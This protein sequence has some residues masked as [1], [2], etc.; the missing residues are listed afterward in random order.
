[1]KYSNTDTIS[2]LKEQISGMES[3]LKVAKLFLALFGGKEKLKEMNENITQLKAQLLEF[4]TIPDKFNSLFSKY[5]WIAYETINFEFMKKQIQLEESGKHEEAMNGFFEYYSNETISFLL[6]R[7]YG[8]DEARIRI[9]FIQNAFIDYKAEKYYAMIPVVIMMIDGIVNDIIGKGFHT[10]IES[11]DVWDSITSIDNGIN[12]IQSVFRKG[13]YKTRIEPINEPYRNGILHGI[14]LGYAN[15]TVAVKTWNYLFVVVD[16]AKAKKSEDAR[17]AKF[18]KDNEPVKL[19]TVLEKIQKTDVVKKE[20]EKW[21]KTEYSIEYINNLNI[22]PDEAQPDTAEYI[23][24]QYFKNIKLKNYKELSVLFWDNYFYSTMSR[25]QQIKNDYKD[26]S[27]NDF[28]IIEIIDEAPVI[29][30]ILI[31]TDDKKL[32][33]RLI[34]QS[35]NEDIALPVLENGNWRIVGVREV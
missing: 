4:E 35:K 33:M 31:K 9:D 24:I 3:L 1:M 30:E 29:K 23:C 17:R 28:V 6:N 20:V 13:R 2:K 26:I 19:K 15:K 11:F 27:Y 14:D 16:W 21:T 10:E 32:K 34:Y 18:E 12:T 25:I 22:H 8:L 7:L 5:G